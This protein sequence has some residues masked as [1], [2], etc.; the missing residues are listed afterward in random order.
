MMTPLDL[1][2]LLDTPLRLRRRPEPMAGDL[3]IGWGMAAV[4]IILEYSRSHRSSFQRLHFLGH[5]MR[6]DEGRDF[7]KSLLMPGRQRPLPLVRAQP[8][9]NRAVGF[10][11][12][13]D[14][15]KVDG[16]T[17]ALTPTA[18]EAAVKELGSQSD[19]MTT[20]RFFLAEIKPFATE[21][22]IEA[23]MRVERGLW[24]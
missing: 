20:E 21:K 2:G 11:A 1:E 14:L 13:L 9:L 16:K 5:A 7:A 12:A 18:G 4:L 19:L 24:A 22:N 17:I 15:I 10:A 6:T 23:A 8:W 3:R